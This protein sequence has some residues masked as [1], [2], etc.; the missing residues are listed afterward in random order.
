MVHADKERIELGVCSKSEV[1]VVV[2]V[3]VEDKVARVVV[4]IG[5][6]GTDVV[7]RMTGSPGSPGSDGKAVATALFMALMY[8]A[9][10]LLLVS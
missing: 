5:V 6:D 4:K 7:L 3:G 10:I 1:V 8:S 9:Q 2:E